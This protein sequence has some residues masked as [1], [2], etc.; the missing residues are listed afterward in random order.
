MDEVPE[1]TLMEIA[2]TLKRLAR[3]LGLRSYNV[4][5]NNG[6][7]SNDPGV[8]RDRSSAHHVHFHLIPRTRR[9]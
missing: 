5:Q 9:D 8:S 4:L 3:A 6:P 2:V 7:Y 1:A